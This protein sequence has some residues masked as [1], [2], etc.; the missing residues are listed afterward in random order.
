VSI[1]FQL[2]PFTNFFYF[3]FPNPA[4]ILLRGLGDYC[5]LP[6]PI[7]IQNASKWRRSKCSFSRL[8]MCQKILW[9]SS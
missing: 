6:Q 4:A 5:K 1:T 3:S 8:K 7:K 2:S 9:R